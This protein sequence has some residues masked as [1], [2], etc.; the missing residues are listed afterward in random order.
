MPRD[1]LQQH[2]KS[3]L[4]HYWRACL[5]YRKTVLVAT[6]S[7]T[8]ASA[9]N[10][11]TPL[12]FK[13]FF[14]LLS[15]RDASIATSLVRVLLIIGALRLAQWACWRLATFTASYFQSKVMTDLTNMCF[16]YLQKHSF[17]FFTDNFV[18]SLVKKVKWFS[19]SFEVISDRTL[20]NLLPLAVNATII[21]SVLFNRNEWLGFGVV[22]WLA[23]FFMVNAIFIRF[24]LRYDIARSQAET[25]ATGFLADTITNQSTIKLFDG[26]DRE[27][28]QSGFLHEQLRRLR[29]KTWNF[30]NYFEAAQGFLM[31]ILEVVILYIAIKLWQRGMLTVGDFV[32]IQSYLMYIFSHIWDFG[33][34]FRE[35]E[36]RKRR[37]F[38]SL[39]PISRSSSS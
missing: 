7:V 8:V 13:Q 37:I 6:V 33:K 30:G 12:Y 5:R 15:A 9:L 11:I 29:L 38:R 1:A 10:A 2:T 14:D 32:L 19:R 36:T 21:I 26:Y 3:T 23:V 16:A 20:W 25:K 18:G 35:V 22:V 39:G 31:I 28:E 4:R 17:G 24:K 34:I 27:V